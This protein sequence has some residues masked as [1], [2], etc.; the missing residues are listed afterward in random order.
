MMLG[1]SNTLSPD[2]HPLAL[3][4]LTR[5]NFDNNPTAPAQPLTATLNG[6]KRSNTGPVSEFQNIQSEYLAGLNVLNEKRAAAIESLK[7]LGF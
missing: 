6:V 7:P 2:F 3:K 4:G 5:G 1:R